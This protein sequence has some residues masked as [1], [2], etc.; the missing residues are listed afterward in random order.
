M[1]FVA[2]YLGRGHNQRMTAYTSSDW[3][4]FALATA[5]A[6]A[7][8]GGLLLVA[9]GLSLGRLL[10]VARLTGRA[11]LAL[12]VL[13]SVLLASSLL[14]VPGQTHVVLGVEIAVLGLLLGIG[15]V[16]WMTRAPAVPDLSRLATVSP[17]LLALTPAAGFVVGGLSLEAQAGG[18]LYWVLG[19]CLA[20]IVGALLEGWAVL[21]EANR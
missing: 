10:E 9:T 14:L 6:S 12:T 18:G 21:L 1:L 4:L 16:V 20:G 3:S 8:L 15:G 11:T 7:A 13:V 2:D 17:A 5:A 19:A